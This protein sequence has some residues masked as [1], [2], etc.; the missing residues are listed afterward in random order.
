MN[1]FGHHNISGNHKAVPQTH[2]LKPPLENAVGSLPRQQCLPTITTEGQKVRTAALLV[3]N[4]PICHDGRILYPI[5]RSRFVVTHPSLE[6]SEGW[7]TLAVRV[8]QGYAT[9]LKDGFARNAIA[10]K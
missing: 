1:V 10:A 5:R 2:S 4:K 6:K 7:G 3:T 9:R 8:I